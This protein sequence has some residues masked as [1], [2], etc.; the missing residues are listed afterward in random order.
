L[1]KQWKGGRGI[2]KREKTAP[3]GKSKIL[4][5]WGIEGGNKKNGDIKATRKVPRDKKNKLMAKKFGI[6][7]T[8]GGRSQNR[9]PRKVANSRQEKKGGR[10]FGNP[11]NAMK[12]RRRKLRLKRRRH[13]DPEKKVG[14]NRFPRRRRRQKRRTKDTG[15]NGSQE[16]K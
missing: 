9:K 6:K 10:D 13:M 7:T 5:E 16:K 8:A 15:G 11:E 14:K 1:E 3:Q 4:F 2:K 12:Q